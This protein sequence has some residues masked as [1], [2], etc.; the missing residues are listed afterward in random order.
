[1]M[2]GRLITC[3]D[4]EN[5]WENIQIQYSN[6]WECVGEAANLTQKYLDLI[7]KFLGLVLGILVTFSET[8]ICKILTIFWEIFRFNIKFVWEWC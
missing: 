5:I 6:V 1:M 3:L 4:F 8:C 2:V 7:F